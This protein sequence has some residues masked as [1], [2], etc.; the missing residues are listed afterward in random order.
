MSLL[1]Q[2]TKNSPSNVTPYYL[3]IMFL[4]L[5][6][7][8]VSL[9][10]FVDITQMTWHTD[11][12]NTNLPRKWYGVESVYRNTT[13]HAR[14]LPTTL[15]GQYHTCTD[16]PITDWGY[17]QMRFKQKL[18]LYDHFRRSGIPIL[19]QPHVC[20]H[21]RT[22]RNGASA[23]SFGGNNG[24]REPS[25]SENGGLFLTSILFYLTL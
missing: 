2:P 9:M 6:V 21:R 17:K 7:E 12:L 8:Q 20:V 22:R 3:V 23:W 18:V 13:H 5:S 1:Y 11:S 15:Y 24:A 16:S 14:S 10:C 19:R 25:R 4:F